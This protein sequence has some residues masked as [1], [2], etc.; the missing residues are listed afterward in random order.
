MAMLNNQ[1]IEMTPSDVDPQ[2]FA[3]LVMLIT[4]PHGTL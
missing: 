2:S 3:D 1:R 4:Q